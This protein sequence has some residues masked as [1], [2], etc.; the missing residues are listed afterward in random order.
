MNEIKK[1]LE[2]DK[3]VIGKDRTLKLLRKG[4]LEKVYLA[5]NLDPESLED[6]ERYAELNKTEVIKIKLNNDEL[7]T[8]CKKPFSIAVM[9][10]QK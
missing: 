3:L 2:S 1:L 6:I 10:L 8:F 4:E 9:G 7:G 5:N